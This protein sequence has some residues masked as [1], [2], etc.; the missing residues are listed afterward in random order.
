MVKYYSWLD[1]V[2]FWRRATILGGIFIFICAVTFLAT[3]LSF[4]QVVSE[5]ES[6]RDSIA[7]FRSDLLVL[8]G[9]GT[10]P[11]I[12]LDINVEDMDAVRARIGISTR[13]TRMGSHTND[14]GILLLGTYEP[15][16]ISTITYYYQ[17]EITVSAEGDANFYPYD[18]YTVNIPFTATKDDPF[19]DNSTM[20][21]L[22]A[23]AYGTVQGYAF[24]LNFIRDPDYPIVNLGIVVQR[25]STTIGF[26]VFIMILMWLIA[27]ASIIVVEHVVVRQRE[28]PPPLIGAF[29]TLLF[30]LPALRNVQP[31]IPPIGVIADIASLF[32]VMVINTICCIVL[33]ISWV[34]QAPEAKPPAL[35]MRKTEAG[36][37]PYGVK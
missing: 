29:V 21:Y 15:T 36:Q 19:G 32:F 12:Y 31:S 6:L 17:R 8:M 14:T 23:T 9:D 4:R 18:K 30:A 5:I 13:V 34:L 20:L 35:T 33:I 24:T 2:P 26:S 11:T 28:V 7:S 3:F 10:Q 16:N 22:N 37:L 27:M 25:S 1:D